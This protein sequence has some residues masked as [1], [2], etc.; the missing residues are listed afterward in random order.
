M[1]IE[2]I[3]PN[4]GLDSQT[5]NEDDQSATVEFPPQAFSGL[6]KDYLELVG[7]CTEAPSP[8]HWV[9]FLTMTGLLLGRNVFM[10]QPYP[11]YP[12]FYSLLIG[13]TGLGRK[14]TAMKCGERELL[15]RVENN[16]TPVKG[17]LSAKVFTRGYRCERVLVFFFIAMKCAPFLMY[18]LGKEQ[19][20]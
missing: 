18:P 3:E 9:T 19:L 16:V 1:D 12:N 10:R 20:T 13:R 11:V 8:Y 5:T 15:G 2:T 4:E 17:A 7:S 14:S 6:F